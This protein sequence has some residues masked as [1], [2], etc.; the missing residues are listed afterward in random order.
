MRAV[1]LLL[2]VAVTH[3][4]I[5]HFAKCVADSE[6][7]CAV[8]IGKQVSDV[9]RAGV[10]RAA[11]PLL[12]YVATPSGS[13]VYQRLWDASAKALPEIAMQ[14][15]GFASGASLDR[16]TARV[17]A[18]AAEISHFAVRDGSVHIPVNLTSKSCSDYHSLGGGASA[19]EP[20]LRAWVHNED[21]T[22]IDG[23]ESFLTDMSVAGVRRLGFSYASNAG[24]AGWAWSVNSHGIAQSVNALNPYNLSDDGIA[25]AMLARHVAGST[26]LDDAVNR[27]CGLQLASGAHF[28]LGSIHEPERQLMIEASNVGCDVRTLSAPSSSSHA[29]SRR[30]AGAA[31]SA[32]DF[33]IGFHAN[34]YESA[35]LRGIDGGASAKGIDAPSSVHRMARMGALPPA[36]TTRALEAVVSDT[37]DAQYPI[38]RD[39]HLP[40]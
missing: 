30:A 18:L 5:D 14:I 40:E 27:T 34:L 15:D 35:R 12:K 26:S 7:A 20:L 16:H 24:L 1:L 23:V 2:L 9:L 37:H 10:L 39:A 21:G 32:A 31:G 38:H 33:T 17:A 25:I 4:N 28:N 13:A 22:A 11:Q 6:H 8:S 3:A 36:Q 19:G 29:P